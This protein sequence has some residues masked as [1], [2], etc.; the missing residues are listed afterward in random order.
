MTRSLIPFVLTELDGDAIASA[1]V[2]I[3]NRGGG[4]AQVFAA[5]TGTT[6]LS[7]PV[8]TDATGRIPGWLE[9]GSYTVTV[10]GSGITTYSRA[11]E[12][13]RGE[14]IG[15]LATGVITNA[16]IVDA[17]VTTVKIADGSV[18]TSKV[19]ALQVTNGK[20]ATDAA[21]T[22]T[23]GDAQADEQSFAT[24][25]VTTVK[26]ADGAVQAQHLT[27][28]TV[29]TAN[30]LDGGVSST[31]LAASSV[32]TAEILDANVTN[33]KIA[34]NAISQGTH[35]TNGT[36]QASHL[37]N[38]VLPAG[39][40]LFAA[41][42]ATPTGWAL[43]DGAAVSRAGNPNLFAAVGTTFGAG[44]GSTTF[45]LPDI[46]GRQLIG[47]HPSGHANVNAVGDN[48]GAALSARKPDHSHGVGNLSLGGGGH[49]HTWQA[50]YDGGCSSFSIVGTMYTY[51]KYEGNTL[52]GT[53]GSGL[54]S[55]EHN[56]SFSGWIGAGDSV[57]PDN[58]GY[59][60]V[61]L[62][63]KLG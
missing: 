13:I 44:D 62:F 32:N 7:N 38:D 60:T 40:V 29:A 16:K 35:I 23:L 51:Q 52:A 53:F 8:N 12:I 36:I 21:S 39:T 19:A 42:S 61:N 6:E 63:I 18:A 28:L 55:S 20:L 10:T 25:S 46:R 27:A 22:R 2:L 47:R 31:A 1:N 3:Q 5:E 57:G 45:N 26:V 54:G 37:A 58:V 11:L 41:N 56:H 15:R 50:P 59:L 14:G 49:N 30:L 33:A 24:D 9:E 17:N 4:S 43:C 34:D 48:D